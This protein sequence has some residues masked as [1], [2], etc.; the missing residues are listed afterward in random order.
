MKTRKFTV[1]DRGELILEMY[2]KKV[3]TIDTFILD[4]YII[5]NGEQKGVFLWQIWQSY[6]SFMKEI[7]GGEYWRNDNTV[8]VKNSYNISTY[9]QKYF[10]TNGIFLK[11]EK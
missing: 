4:N 1:T 9:I 6:E 11:T 5:H 3:P 8:D 7:Y 10:A 2:S